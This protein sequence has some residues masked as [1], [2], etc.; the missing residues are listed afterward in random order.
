MFE[1]SRQVIRPRTKIKSVC[2]NDTPQINISSDYLITAFVSFQYSPFSF[3]MLKEREEKKVWRYR[4][5]NIS[6]CNTTVP[7]RSLLANVC[8]LRLQFWVTLRRQT[9]SDNYSP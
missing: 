4:E 5:Q 6:R 7:V 1:I 9:Q 2:Q 8:N 3:H